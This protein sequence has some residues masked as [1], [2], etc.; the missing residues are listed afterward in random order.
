MT[1]AGARAGVNV[2]CIEKL[3]QGHLYPLE[4]HRDKPRQ[5]GANLRPPA[6]QAATLPEE[7][8]RQFIRWLFGASTA[9]PLLFFIYVFSTITL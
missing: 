3:D 6:P 4:E 1:R 7:L 9:A 2:C 5:G 8:S